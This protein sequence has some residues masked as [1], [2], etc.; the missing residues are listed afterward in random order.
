MFSDTIDT[1]TPAGR[2]YGFTAMIGIGCGSYLAAGFSVV[3]AMLP[4]QDV[5]NAVGFMSIGKTSYSNI[6]K[7]TR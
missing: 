4:V 5:M 6:F 3:Q 2:I 7:A 1:D